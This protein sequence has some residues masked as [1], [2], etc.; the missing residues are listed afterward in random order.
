MTFDNIIANPPY[1]KIGRDITKYILDNVSYR[2]ISMLGTG[3]MFRKH[4]D[5]LNIE[6]VYITDWVLNPLSKVKWVKQT[7]L[8]G[9]KGHCEVVPAKA[10][11]RHCPERPNEIRV[12]FPMRHSGDLH[13]S[14]NFLLTRSRKTSCML[15]LSDEDYE[16]ITAH[17]D[18]MTRTE[19]FWWLYDKG[20]YTRYEQK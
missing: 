16:Y 9:H 17:W 1:S 18:N 7:I 2:D 14:L 6:H 5:V 15:Y 13:I 11:P 19:R 3:A 4:N 12:P 8:L 10:V 20:L